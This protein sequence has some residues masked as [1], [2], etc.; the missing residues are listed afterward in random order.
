MRKLI[1]ALIFVL[2]MSCASFAANIYRPDKSSDEVL[3]SL[4]RDRASLFTVQKFS[5]DVSGLSITYNVYA[6]K[7]YA[8]TKHPAVFFIADAS[9]AGKAPS[10]SLTQ[11]YGALVWPDDCIVIVPTY[12]EMILD[13]HNGF[14]VTDYVELTGRFVR[15]MIDAYNIDASRVYATGQSMG[16]MTSL[17]LA[18]RY[19]DLFTA[20]LFVSGQWDI[21][22]LEGLKARKFVYAASLGDDKASKGQQ[23]VIDMFAQS[24]VQFTHYRNV[25][26]KAPNI[27]LPESQR[28]SFVTFRK[29]TTLPEGAEGGEHMSS[30]D[31]AYR[32]GALREWL[33]AQ[34][35]EN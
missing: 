26:A 11:G 27:A 35:K 3:Q 33:L 30:F 29:G 28:V 10:F 6:P 16:C 2:I 18:A 7:D 25:D 14:V 23:E 9:A 13:D 19:E 8:T 5:D 20:C 17:I 34:R 24:D 32:T 15:S 22:E 1:P 4:I 12:P 21:N 31:F